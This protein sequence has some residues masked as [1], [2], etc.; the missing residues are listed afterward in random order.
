MQLKKAI[1]N[2]IT[3]M[4]I[5]L[6]TLAILTIVCNES[7]SKYLIASIMI[8]VAG[9]GDYLDGKVARLLN[10]ESELGKQLDSSS[11]IMVF[12]LAPVIVGFSLYMNQLNYIGYVVFLVYVLAGTYRLARYNI[13]KFEGAYIGLPITLAGLIVSL[14]NIIHW[15]FIY[16][17]E[18]KSIY[19]YVTHLIILIVSYLMISKIQVKKI[20]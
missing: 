8:F 14:L 1:P 11:D 20:K 18:H 15:Y 13:T 5:C 4:N 9:F 17:K 12:G 10:A 3:C 6:G 19:V 7:E 2:L 16:Y